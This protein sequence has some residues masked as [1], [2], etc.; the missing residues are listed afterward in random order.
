M[1]SPCQR[2]QMCAAAGLM[3]LGAGAGARAAQGSS[4]A[5]RTSLTNPRAAGNA[6]LN[7]WGFEVYTAR[8]WVDAGFTRADWERHAF[9]LEL[10]YLRSFKGAQIAQRS[11]EEMT[12]QTTLTP[13]QTQAWGAWLRTALPDVARAD[14]LVGVYKP[15]QLALWHNGRLLQETADALLAAR[16]MAIWLGPQTSQPKLREQLLRGTS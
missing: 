10:S 6:K 3:L 11:L 5:W 12:R 15:G 13:E 8:L 4:E 1:D 16:F 2:R 14:R 7:Y 9:A